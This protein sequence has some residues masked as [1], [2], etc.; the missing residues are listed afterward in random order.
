MVVGGWP[1]ESSALC[2]FL[3]ESRRKRLIVEEQ[4]EKNK[5]FYINFNACHKLKNSEP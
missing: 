1:G 2:V 5:I 3:S 4:K